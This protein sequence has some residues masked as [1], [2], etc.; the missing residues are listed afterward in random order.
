MNNSCRIYIVYDNDEVT[1]APINV[2]LWWRQPPRFFYD[3]KIVPP[4]YFGHQQL[5]LAI[6][7]VNDGSIK[8][9][10]FAFLETNIDQ[11]KYKGKNYTDNNNHGSDKK[12]VN[13]T[14][15]TLD[16]NG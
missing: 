7:E 2:K 13:I 8:K 10:D 9:F 16:V 6:A 5:V 12:V 4:D 3:S 11:A 14:Y 1:G 15:L